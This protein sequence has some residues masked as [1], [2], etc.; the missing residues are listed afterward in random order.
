MSAIEEII[1]MLDVINEKIE[2]VAMNTG[3]AESATDNVLAQAATLGI[4]ATLESLSQV[5]DEIHQLLS[6]LVAAGDS[7]KQAMTT[8]RAV[9]DST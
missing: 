9:A 5:K 8:A 3:A 4:N 7:A 6:Q 2:E 1:Q